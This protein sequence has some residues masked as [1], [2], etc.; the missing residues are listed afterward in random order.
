MALR[1][2]GLRS[3]RGEFARVGGIE[4]CLGALCALGEQHACERKLRRG[5]LIPRPY[6]VAVG[7]AAPVW[8]IQ[9]LVSDLLHSLQG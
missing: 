7:N 6:A 2:P 8:H 9:I 1:E 5:V 3:R 4:H